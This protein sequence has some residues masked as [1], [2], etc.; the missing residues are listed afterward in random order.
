MASSANPDAAATSPSA[1]DWLAANIRPVAYGLIVAGL[2]LLVLSFVIG[3][4]YPS[5]FEV[6]VTVSVTA[7]GEAPA[8]GTS[9]VPATVVA[10]WV[11]F[12]GGILLTFGVLPLAAGPGTFHEREALRWQVLACGTALG[13]VSVLAG[14]YLVYAWWGDLTAWVRLGNREKAWRF[15]LALGALIVGLAVMFLSM[16]SVRSE[17]RKSANLRRVIYGYNSFLTGFLLLLILIVVNVGAALAWEPG[18]EEGGA[19]GGEVDITAGGLYSLSD[20]TK[21]ILSS[22]EQPAKVYVILPTGSALYQEVVALLDNC[23][24][25]ARGNLRVETLSP[26]TNLPAI[27]KLIEIHKQEF[28]M[29]R[30]GL[31]GTA[32]V[33]GLL[34]TYGDK[35]QQAAFIPASDLQSVENDPQTFEPRSRTFLGEVKLDEVLLNLSEAGNRPVVYVLQGHGEMDLNDQGEESERGAG[36]FQQRLTRRGN[37][38]VKP[39]TL[40]D[41]NANVPPDASMLVILGPER[42]FPQEHVRAITQYVNDRKGKLLALFGAVKTRIGTGTGMLPTGLEDLLRLHNVDVTGEQILM[43]TRTVEIGPGEGYPQ[44]PETLLATLDPSMQSSANPLAGLVRRAR[45]IDVSNARVIRGTNFRPN[46]RAE[47]LIST[48]PGLIYWTETNMTANTSVTDAA[49]HRDPKFRGD[50][51]AP[52]PLPLAVLVSESAEPAA[53]GRPAPEGKPR[54]AVFGSTSFASNTS[55][56]Q[57]MPSTY[58]DLLAGSIDWLREKP[59]GI[60]V[61]PKTTKNF[62]LNPATTDWKGLLLLPL[63]VTLL[64][65]VGLGGGVWLARRR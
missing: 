53:P 2:A 8:S 26:E 10:T 61:E 58:F 17:E 3:L 16:Q 18:T 33:P 59:A 4:K 23:Q 51:R 21:N 54:L 52:Q 14:L 11:G 62:V 20:R 34:V 56:G 45:F 1:L 43:M 49:M 9:R 44:V 6:P 24:R 41:A 32:Y 29:T 39:L 15:L 48:V 38:T 13:V 37:L 60:G 42:P 28:A 35:E 27:R 36:L 57:G 7:G 5:S 65:I 22:L 50:H 55:M 46:L 47:Q 63:G 30:P 19:G 25:E 40:P 12:L 64:G 31:G